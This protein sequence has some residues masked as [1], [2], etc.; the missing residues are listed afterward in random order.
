MADPLAGLELG[1]GRVVLLALHLFSISDFF[2]S[3]PKIMGGGG[4]PTGSFPSRSAVGLIYTAR[5]SK[6]CH[7]I[8]IG[9]LNK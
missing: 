1:R 8:N 2:A 6:L 9:S 3:L 7:Q 5:P 4:A